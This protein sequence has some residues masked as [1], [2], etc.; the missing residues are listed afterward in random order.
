MYSPS[1]LVACARCCSEKNDVKLKSVLCSMS[2]GELVF[3]RL[4][5]AYP[6]WHESRGNQTLYMFS[7]SFGWGLK[8][9]QSARLLSSKSSSSSLL[10]FREEFD[11]RRNLL[12]FTWEAN[13]TKV[14]C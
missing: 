5:N 1:S 11:R 2:R 7:P 6:Q 4:R 8:A 13:S 10:M 9:S 3:M 12:P 14:L